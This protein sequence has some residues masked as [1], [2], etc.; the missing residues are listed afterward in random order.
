MLILF[1]ERLGW[2]GISVFGVCEMGV[3]FVCGL[4]W[5][6][7]D[8]TVGSSSDVSG[9]CRLGI[10]TSSA[11]GRIFYCWGGIISSFLATMPLSVAGI[12]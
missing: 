3:G 5:A 10:G 6:A 2:S 11:M 8:D 9:F 1:L 7:W 4:E 12:L